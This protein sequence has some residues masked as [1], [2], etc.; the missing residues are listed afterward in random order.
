MPTQTPASALRGTQKVSRSAVAAPGPQAHHKAK[1][2]LPH[3]ADAPKAKYLRSLFA[4][5]GSAGY[6]L[7]AKRCSSLPCSFPILVFMVWFSYTVDRSG[8]FQGELAPAA[9]WT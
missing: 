1:N 9:L 6:T 7:A 8:L 2:P 5:F 3:R 4:W